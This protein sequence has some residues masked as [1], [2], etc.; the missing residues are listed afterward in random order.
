MRRSHCF[1]HIEAILYLKELT[2]KQNSPHTRSHSSHVNIFKCPCASKTRKSFLRNTY[3][4][5]IHTY[6]YILLHVLRKHFAVLCKYTFI[7]CT[8]VIVETLHWSF[9]NY[10]RFWD[11]FKWYMKIYK[12][13]FW[14]IVACDAYLSPEAIIYCTCFLKKNLFHNLHK[15]F[16]SCGLILEMAVA[17]MLNMI[18]TILKII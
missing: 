8:L 7:Y 3:I 1:T 13:H 16:F 4:I 2:F 6:I 10:V 17:R 18:Y 15:Y 9:M 14:C 5:H 12:V 11:T